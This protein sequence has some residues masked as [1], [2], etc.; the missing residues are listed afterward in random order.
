MSEIRVNTVSNESGTGSVDF[1]QG[2]TLPSGKSLSGS[3]GINVSG[4]CT[5]SGGFVGNV[6]GNVTAGD[7][8]FTADVSVAGKLGVGTTVPLKALQVGNFTGNGEIVLASSTSGN[9]TLFMGDGTSDYYRGYVQYEN[10]SDSM[11][12]A[13]SSAEHMRLTSGGQFL[14]NTTSNGGNA[15]PA[16]MV[17]GRANAETD[18]GMM[19]IKRG[20]AAASMSAGDSVGEITFSALDGGQCAQIFAKAGIG[21]T[22]TP[23][24]PGELIFKTTSDGSGTPTEKVRIQSGGGLSFNGDTATTNALDDYEE[25]TWTPSIGGNATYT[26]QVGT[27]VKVGRMVL[28][29]WA[30]TINAQGTG[31]AISAISGLPFTSGVAGQVTSNLLWSGFGVSMASAVYY[32]GNASTSMNLSYI[33][34]AATALTNNPNGLVNGATINGTMIYYST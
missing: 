18:S 25:G 15:E 26:S 13:T 16:L 4:I 32:V 3:G 33:A 34:T 17:S 22:G 31:S 8:T 20:E 6:T 10:S 2:A 14:I 30:L 21:W 12:F 1:I 23:D 11:I 5:A 27:Y 9:C 24:S 7:S 28:A 29:Q 19:H